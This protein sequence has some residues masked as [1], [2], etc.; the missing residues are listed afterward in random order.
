[1]KNKGLVLWFSGLSGAGKSTISQSLKQLMSNNNEHTVILDGDVLRSGLCSDL[2]FSAED[3]SENIRRVS[4]FAK[5][6]A[7]NGIFVICALISPYEKDRMRAKEIIGDE[8]F[9]NVYIKAD[10]ETC[11]NRDPKGLYKKAISGE[12]KQFTGISDIFEEPK[13]A[14]L[15]ID[16][17]ENT[18]KNC[19]LK[20]LNYVNEKAFAV[21][22]V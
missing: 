21:E 10:I 14:D 8:Y 4:E 5:L 22:S 20:L 19:T 11:I 13:K 1:M 2:G 7:N 18:I 16:T 12:I 6:L 3:R 9:H 15:I 17:K